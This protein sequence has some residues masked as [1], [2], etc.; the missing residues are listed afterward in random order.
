M[1]YL[2]WI[3]SYPLAQATTFLTWLL[4]PLLALCVTEID[5]REWLIKPLRWFQTFDAPL[6]E[7]RCGTYY[8]NCNWLKW[9]FTKPTHRYLA[10]VF[11]LYRNPAYGFAQYPLGINAG[12]LL[13]VT[14]HGKWDNG[15]NNREFTRW[16]NAFNFRA[17]WFFYGKRYLRINIGWKAH[18]GFSRLM[19]ATHISPFRTYHA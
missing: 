12:R 19:L 16:E 13:S 5:G 11:W 9:D 2:R 6:D 4:A 3:L 1:I 18:H 15:S 17:Q 8:K 14:Y 7:W 10:R